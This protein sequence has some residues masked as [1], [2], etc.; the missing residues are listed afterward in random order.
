MSAPVTTIGSSDYVFQAIALMRRESLRH[1]PVVDDQGALVGM[2][3]LHH[4]LGESIPMLLEM[5]ETLTPRDLRTGID[6]MKRAQ[7]KIAL[8][9]LQDGVPVP[10]IQALLTHFN[11][12]IYRRIIRLAIFELHE[13][14]LGSPPIGFAVDRST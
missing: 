6:H 4:A 14:G 1:L 12:D 8:G 13:A 5:I 9:L 10:E 2:L 7:V 11:N 3:H